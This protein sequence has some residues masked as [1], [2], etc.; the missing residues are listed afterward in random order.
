MCV[1]ECVFQLTNNGFVCWLTKKEKRDC[2]LE[3]A[4]SKISTRPLLIGLANGNNL[5]PGPQ[6]VC[7]MIHEFLIDITSLPTFP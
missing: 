6:R 1:F 5:Q 4:A 3:M 7:Q 2:K